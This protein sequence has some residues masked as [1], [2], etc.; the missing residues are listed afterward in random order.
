M[1][2]RYSI[3]PC[4]NSGPAA[5]LNHEEC[6]ELTRLLVQAEVAQTYLALRALDAE[7]ALVQDTAAT[8]GAMRRIR[9]ESKG[10][11]IR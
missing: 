2:T 8:A 10:V 6:N 3:S 5:G 1:T 4:L 11:G 9:R 7:R